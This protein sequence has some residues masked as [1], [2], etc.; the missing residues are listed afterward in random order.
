MG[1]AFTLDGEEVEVPQHNPAERMWNGTH[2]YDKTVIVISL[3]GVRADY[4]ERGLTPHLLNI[5]RKGLVSH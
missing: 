3:D 4:L 2:W 1:D 5:S